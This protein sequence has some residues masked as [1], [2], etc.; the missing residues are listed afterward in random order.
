[1][2]R[3]DPALDEMSRML[4][5]LTVRSAVYCISDF[6]APWGFRV[7]GSRTAKFHLVLSGTA[8]LSLEGDGEQDDRHLRPG[9]FVVLPHG[10]QHVVRDKRGSRVR[11]LDRILADQPVTRSGELRYGGNGPRT[12]LLCGGF[13]LDGAGLVELLPPVLVL[14][15]SNTRI[16]TW[17]QPTFELLRAETDNSAPGTAAVLSKIADVF[18]TQVLRQYLSAAE[19]GDSRIVIAVEDAHVARAAALLR[20][21]PARQWTVA[22]LAREV[23]MSRT[24]LASRF[25]AVVGEPPMTYLSRVRLGQAAAHLATTGDNLRHIA[26]LVGYSNEAALSKA[27]KRSFGISPST[28]RRQR[29]DNLAVA[30]G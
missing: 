1:M 3:L 27:F 15:A 13:E 28:F 7:E 2:D 12:S 23:G 4:R 17:L 18:L 22:E 6:G 20:R 24:A 26:H 10:S 16:A 29:S 14:D 25:S 8:V 9:D 21:S 19:P 11:H 30:V 5:E